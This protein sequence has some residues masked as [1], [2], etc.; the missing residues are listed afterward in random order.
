MSVCLC[1]RVWVVGCQAEDEMD[2]PQCGWACGWQNRSNC[3]ASSMPQESFYRR[4]L[5][6]SR[7]NHRDFQNIGA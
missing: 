4:M 5:N 1:M 7:C 6:R 3:P 2:W